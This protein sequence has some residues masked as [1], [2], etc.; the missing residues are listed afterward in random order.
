MTKNITPSFTDPESAIN[1]THTG[2]NGKTSEA[3]L[4]KMLV[5]EMPDDWYAI[6]GN[7][8][9]EHE[10]DFLVAVPG[11]GVVNLECKGRYTAD[12]NN[13]SFIAPDGKRK[14]PISQACE[15]MAFYSEELG[16]LLNKQH[17]C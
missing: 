1:P 5:E 8:L 6:W 3:A 12:A 14:F 4:Y 11:R 10:Y 7:N 16:R 13:G 2:G 9:G 15:A 17:G